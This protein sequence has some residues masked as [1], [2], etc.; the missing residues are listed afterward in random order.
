VK[1]IVVGAGVIGCAVAHELASRGVVV[2]LLDDRA[3]G[4]GATQASAGILA[5][6]SDGHSPV[7]VGLCRTSLSMYDA[8][9]ARVQ[10]DSGATVEYGRN[11]AL[12]VSFDDERAAWLRDSAAELAQAGVPHALLTAA[13]ARA[14]EPSL[15]DTVV[16]AL[17]VQGQ[18]YVAALALTQALAQGA[19]RR[20]ATLIQTRVRSIEG[21]DGGATVRTDDGAIDADAVVVTAGSWATAL[22]GRHG[23]D[24]RPIRGQLLRLRSE[25]R[26]VSRVVWGPR[27]YVVP[28]RDGTL[29]VGAT[30]EDVG[31]DE[32]ATAAGVKGLLEVSRELLPGLERAAFDGVRV[33]LRPKGPG[34]LPVIGWSPTMPNVALAVGHHR[35]GVTLAPLTAA[36]VADVVLDERRRA[37]L[38]VVRPDRPLALNGQP[39]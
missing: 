39:S 7:L 11:G 15:P 29:L 28:W 16:S 33:G 23:P 12:H 22:L 24:V 36:L 34:E 9:I 6:S 5:P 18:G 20:G 37:E 26:L 3:P 32:R 25:E 14:E 1:T 13:A 35:N 27:C 30:V 21:R 17:L 10:E 8:F 2:H 38:D 31:F 19:I 4:M